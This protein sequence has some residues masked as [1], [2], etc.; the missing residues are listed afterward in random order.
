MKHDLDA[1]SREI[2]SL[3]KTSGDTGGSGDTS[4]K[5][6]QTNNFP[7][8]TRRVA[9]S[10]LVSDWGH[11]VAASGD[12][13]SEH[14][15]PVVERVPSV[16]TATTNLQ[17]GRIGEAEDRTPAH[18]YAILAELER[19]ECPEW[20]IIDRWQHVLSDAETFLTRW[21]SAAHSLGWTALDLFGVHPVAPAARFDV[22]GLIL[23]L[24]GAAVLTLTD[25]TAT[26]RRASGAV[27]TYRRSDQTGA[28]LLSELHP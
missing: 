15:Q 17:G 22:M 19:Q 1:F 4:S 6:L 24:K 8:P 26:M 7:V 12:R 18:W 10:P 5:P 2:V 9:V 27:L 13:K 23:G 20:I 25:T 3:I 16:P 11:G 14:L 21:G 28:I